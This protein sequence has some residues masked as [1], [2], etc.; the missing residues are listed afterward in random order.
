[1]Q[2]FPK[3]I[4][5]KKYLFQRA[6][7]RNAMRQTMENSGRDLSIFLKA[8]ETYSFW[9]EHQLKKHTKMISARANLKT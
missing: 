4:L 7:P 2:H 9:I 6:S 1:M 3:F 5:S 8:Q